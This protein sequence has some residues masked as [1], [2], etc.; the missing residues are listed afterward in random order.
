MSMPTVEVFVVPANTLMWSDY[1]DLDVA[2]VECDLDETLATVIR[3]A[4]LEL[5]SGGTLGFLTE[6][7]ESHQ[8]NPTRGPPAVP[9][10]DGSLRWTS[11]GEREITLAELQAAKAEG[12]FDGDP[13]AF[14]L[15]RRPIGNGGLSLWTQVDQ[16]ID[17]AGPLASAILALRGLVGIAAEDVMRIRRLVMFVVH[18]FRIR[19]DSKWLREFLADHKDRW[20][21]AGGRFTDSV[22]AFCVGASGMGSS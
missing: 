1:S 2:R 17:G 13:Y 10:E 11:Y 20:I 5:G 14:L 9:L 15:D 6:P 3:K 21:D 8:R 12:L 19:R 4:E 7:G 22:A 18:R 16:W